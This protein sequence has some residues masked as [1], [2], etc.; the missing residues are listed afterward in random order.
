MSIKKSIALRLYVYS[1]K[2]KIIVV[3]GFK[4]IIPC[5]AY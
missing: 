3:S 1:E 5:A 2:F 4:G